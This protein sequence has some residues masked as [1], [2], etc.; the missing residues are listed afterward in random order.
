MA[1]Q[2]YCVVCGCLLILSL[3]R[4]GFQDL[5]KIRPSSLLILCGCILHLPAYE[6]GTDGVFRNV[7]KQN[8][9]AGELH[10]KKHTTYR[11]RRKF[12]IMRGNCLLQNKCSPMVLNLW[13]KDPWGGH[14]VTA[15]GHSIIPKAPNTQRT[16]YKF[17][18]VQPL[19][20][21]LCSTL[22]FLLYYYY[23]YY[24]Y[25]YYCVE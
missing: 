14:R 1:G 15:G 24:C 13:D 9:D 8:S 12:E 17:L 11:T 21:I 20:D 16:S 6:D 2:N 7:G 23:Y 10:R 19:L 22:L 3:C 4:R 18:L 25:Y 5:L